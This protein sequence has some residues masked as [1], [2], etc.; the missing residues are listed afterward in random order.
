MMTDILPLSLP[1]SL[2][3]MLAHTPVSRK[4]FLYFDCNDLAG[5][6]LLRADYTIDCN[7]DEYMAFVPVVLAVLAS[8]IIALPGVISYY[9]W[10][11][12]KEL[13]STSVYQKVGWLYDPF[14]R[15][16]E[17]WQVHD[18]LMKMILTGM[19][20]YIPPNSRAG[21]A[22][23]VCVIA[24][25]NLNY[26]RPHKNK[27]LFWLTQLS[28]VTTT[29]KYVVSL[30][31]T[32]SDIS[33]TEEEGFTMSVFLITLDLFF[34]GSSVLAMF[35][36]VF[37]LRARIRQINKEEKATALA[38]KTKTKVA[39]T[40]VQ[41]VEEKAVDQQKSIELRTI[42]TKFGADS[43][44]YTTAMKE[45]QDAREHSSLVN[46]MHH[47]HQQHQQELNNTLKKKQIQ[48]RRNTRLRVEQRTQARA[49][50]KKLK[51]LSRIPAFSSIKEEE[52]QGMI[53]AMTYE[54]YE[55]SAGAVLCHQGDVADTFYVIMK[56]EC[57]AYVDTD[58]DSQ[59]G[60]GISGGR[61]E[62]VGTIP[63]HAF[64]GE[65]S[66]LSAPGSKNAE[67]NATVKIESD[68]LSLL[69]LTK[70]NFYAL[71]DN[72]TLDRSVLQGVQQVEH[73]RH[74]RNVNTIGAIVNA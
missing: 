1:S 66:L 16:A 2:S 5:V 14:V 73:E 57:G 30:L 4:V 9:L 64:F 18:V 51:T 46:Q 17:F 45:L 3:Q 28:F 21:I 35:V 42:R 8:F 56:G 33:D 60:H 59:F 26:F 40:F 22:I 47:E 69:V 12:R 15:G 52:L 31:L 13:Y 6:R 24:C 27:L 34:M 41:S 53:D 32:S 19:I 7:S 58:M 65:S 71:I 44:E 48:Q 10:K 55:D 67:R 62:K 36:S 38:A 61:L 74:D 37:V 54:E 29:A 50:L 11:H 25:C 43:V 72:G 70:K 68:E 23:L 20:I 49:K 39:P 63:T